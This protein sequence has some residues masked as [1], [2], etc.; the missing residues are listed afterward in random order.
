MHGFNWFDRRGAEGVGS[1]RALRTL[2]TNNL[3]NILPDLRVAIAGDFAR[4]MAEHPVVD[5]MQP[6][7]NKKFPDVLCSS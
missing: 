4:M 1:V 5:G 7:L 6:S 2:L 3:P